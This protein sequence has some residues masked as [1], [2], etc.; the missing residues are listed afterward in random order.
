MS[1]LRDTLEV[2]LLPLKNI[3]I[4]PEMIVPVFISEDICYDI[5]KH[6]LSRD[7]LI[8]L[9]A[10]KSGSPEE[11]F[12]EELQSSMEEPYDVYDTGTLSKILKTKRIS[13]GRIQVLV[14]GLKVHHLVKLNSK[15]PIPVVKVSKLQTF[16][17]KHVSH[18]RK[19]K[20]I[21]CIQTKLR[22]L[23]FLKGV[24]S[25]DIFSTIQNVTCLSRLCDLIM[26]YLNS[27][28]ES[29]QIILAQKNSWIKANKVYELIEKQLSSDEEK[30]QKA[31]VVSD[32]N[33]SQEQFGFVNASSDDIEGYKKKLQSMALPSVVK[34]E[35]LK[36]I[37]RLERM[38]PESNESN[39]TRNYLEYIFE[40]P[41]GVQLS[42]DLSFK[43]SEK[44]LNLSHY[45]LQD[46]KDRVLEYI[47][48]RQLNP[49]VKAPILCFIGPPGVGKTSLGKS[50]AKSLGRHFMRISLGGVKDEAEIRGHRRTYVGAMPGKIIQALKM[51]KSL[52]PV[53]MLDEIDKIGSDGRGD[54]SNALL[55]VLDSEQNN[56]FFDHY[57]SLPFDLS[58]VIFIANANDANSIPYAL[59]DRLEIIEISGYYDKEK[60]EIAKKYIL[61]RVLEESGLKKWKIRIQESHLSFIINNYTRESGL[62]SLEKKL[63]SVVRKIARVIAQNQMDSK[64]FLN[65][66]KPKIIELLG[67]PKYLS[68]QFNKKKS[69]IGQVFGLAYTQYG[70]E[71]LEIEAKA[72]KGTGRLVVTGQIGD[73]MQESAKAAMSAVKAMNLRSN[74]VFENSDVHIHV[75]E[76]AVPKDGPSAGVSLAV[77]LVSLVLNRAPM[78]L[79]ALT[80]ELTLSGKILPVGGIKE[81]LLAAVR[82]GVKLVCLP[83]ANKSIYMTLPLHLKSAI[84]V[85]FVDTLDTVIKSCFAM[86]KLNKFESKMASGDSIIAP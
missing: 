83:E 40:L 18:E 27:K 77:A 14:Q 30:H 12:L 20:L 48:V 19:I 58:K 72:F 52:D 62:R 13:D 39:V 6:A 86:R 71:V 10:F 36:C 32:D 79:I 78:P 38:S 53:I 42:K 22:E 8:F 49:D 66:T 4:F 56:A 21:E 69:F 5:V 25:Q 28:I 17:E 73:V 43:E 54:P 68:N 45:G 59:R 41:W 82:E 37:A 26:S 2:P 65:I 64:E 75:P 80:G 46:V 44:M 11:D 57:L 35:C 47:A 7:K 51:A 81:K 1:S 3:V 33:D 85:K 60:V 61:P 74:F 76:G 16:D 9:S 67:P 84:Q 23:T 15:G 55:E 34:K 70:G 31:D 24:I 63:S 50:I 29:S